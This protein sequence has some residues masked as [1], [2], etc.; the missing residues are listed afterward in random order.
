M[1]TKEYLISCL[2]EELA[3]VQK[4]LVKCL[5]F[6]PDHVSPHDQSSNIARA[7][8]EYADAIAIIEMLEAEAA[9]EYVFEDHYDDEDETGIQN[10]INQYA[11]DPE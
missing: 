3:E 6:T 8:L 5:R 4:E 9:I 11:K 10:A 7:G 2:I 1:N